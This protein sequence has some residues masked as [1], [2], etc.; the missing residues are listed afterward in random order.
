MK[1]T[2]ASSALGKTAGVPNFPCYKVHR[3]GLEVAKGIDSPAW[4][5]LPPSLLAPSG[6][7]G[8]TSSEHQRGNFTI[9]TSPPQRGLLKPQ[10]KQPLFLSDH[11][12][13]RSFRGHMLTW[14]R[15]YYICVCICMYI[16]AYTCICICT[17][18]YTHIVSPTRP[19]I[20]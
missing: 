4:P 14:A 15:I 6:P 9:R 5:V 10:T 1:H 12:C 2:H 7:L 13:E 19:S 8:L 20:P 16:C 18:I 11:L 3:P 17:Y